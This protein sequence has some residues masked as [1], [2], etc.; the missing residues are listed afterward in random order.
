[1]PLCCPSRSETLEVQNKCKV[2]FM[3]KVG[4]ICVSWLLKYW[5]QKQ[6]RYKNAS[7]LEWAFLQLISSLWFFLLLVQFFLLQFF[8]PVNF[9]IAL[10]EQPAFP[11]IAYCD[12]SSL[13]RIPMYCWT[14]VKSKVCNESITLDC[15]LL[16]LFSETKIIYLILIW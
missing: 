1:M 15:F 9:P 13:W 6:A 10:W 5:L 16:L 4:H 8:L 7:T 12:L 14:T 11:A 2:S 3:W